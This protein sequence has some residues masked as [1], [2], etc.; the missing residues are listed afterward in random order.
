ML[1]VSQA[2]RMASLSRALA[3]DGQESVK[4]LARSPLTFLFL[5]GN[6]FYLASILAS[7]VGFLEGYSV[8]DLEADKHLVQNS[9]GERAAYTE[10]KKS[11]E[12]QKRLSKTESPYT[13]VYDKHMTELEKPSYSTFFEKGKEYDGTNVRFFKQREA[14]IGK[15]VGNSVDPQK[16]LKRGEGIRYIAP[17]T[18]EQ[19]VFRKAPLDDNRTP[20]G[21]GE[22]RGDNESTP[23]GIQCGADGKPIGDDGSLGGGGRNGESGGVGHRSPNTGVLNG[24]GGENYGSGHRWGD[25]TA[26]DPTKN[27][28]ASNIVEI[29]NMV[30]R[31]RKIQEPLPTSRRNFGKEPA[32][33]SRV[34]KEVCDEKAFVESV[35]E[36]KSQRQQQAY[37]QYVYLLSREEHEKLLQDLRKRKIE[38]VSELQRMPFSKDTIGMRKHKAELEKTVTDI[39]VALKKLDRD[40]VFIYKDDPVNGQ[41]SKEA[42]LKEAQRYAAHSH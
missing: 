38:C 4:K 16:F 15:E 14:I 42:A 31:R 18:H 27:F 37:A 40:A 34:K 39:E 22:R 36:L 25:P 7:A 26:G 35:E 20:F 28:V 8:S 9:T 29:S 32:Y 19:K 6:T 12:L 24:N 3:G 11:A 30:P 1:R 10:L 17:A 41:W 23:T 21:Q 13:G 2:F 33:L 5:S